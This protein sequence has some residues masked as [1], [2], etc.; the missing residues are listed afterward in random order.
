MLAVWPAGEGKLPWADD[1]LLAGP[2]LKPVC[3]PTIIF[4]CGLASGV[5]VIQKIISSKP[6]PLSPQTLPVGLSIVLGTSE[7][8]PL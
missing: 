7:V 3:G 8:L 2:V 4:T 5:Q 6:I 1:T